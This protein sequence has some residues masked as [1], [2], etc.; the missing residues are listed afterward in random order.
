MFAVALL[1]V[2]P[3][4]SLVPGIS[5]TTGTRAAVPL[6]GAAD[7][8]TVSG[9]SLTGVSVTRISARPSV[10]SRSPVRGVAS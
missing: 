4:M 6:P 3:S 10:R 8:N 5:T 9:T 2:T 7:A 1:P